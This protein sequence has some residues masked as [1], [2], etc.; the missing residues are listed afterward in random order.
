MPAVTPRPRPARPSLAVVMPAHD[1]ADAIADTIRQLAAVLAGLGVDWEVLVVDDGSADGTAD[2]VRSLDPALRTSLLRLSRNFGKEAAL[3]AGLDHASADLVLC[4]DADGQHP[5][6][7]VPQMLARWRDG[8]DMVYGVRT[9][10]HREAGFKRLGARLF[11]R[12]M[13]RSGQVDI[14]PDA[15][16][17]RLLD[18]RVVEA[19]RALPER[20]RFMKGLYAWVGFPS[21][22]VPFEP[23]NRTAGETHYSRARLAQLAWLGVTSFSALPLRLASLA[24][25]ALAVA[26]IGYG[27]YELVNKLAFGVDVPGWATIVVGMMFLSGVQLLGIGV[28]G[29]Y[30][31]RVYEE[32]KGRPTYLVAEWRRAQAHGAS[33]AAERPAA[34]AG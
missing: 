9:D 24:G 22:G 7:V 3:S 21:I 32:V 4:V 14:P 15:G 1:E 30:L 18:R 19:L 20:Q 8:Y 11:Y 5:P 6:A 16:D 17:F 13:A 34:A 10:R 2:V 33:A 23:L 27:L 25:A 29:E 31:A 28:L 12:L 26:S